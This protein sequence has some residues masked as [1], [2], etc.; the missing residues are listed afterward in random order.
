MIDPAQRRRVARSGQA[1]VARLDRVFSAEGSTHNC[2][3]VQRIVPYP[4]IHLRLNRTLAA[5]AAVFHPLFPKVSRSL[6]NPADGPVS[7][8]CSKWSY[9]ELA[10][11]FHVNS[12]ARRGSKTLRLFAVPGPHVHALAGSHKAG[13]LDGPRVCQH[14]AKEDVLQILTVQRELGR[15]GS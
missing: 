1:C 11:R 8:V 13:M 6:A 2:F 3:F 9:M 14:Y 5:M 12:A 7:C 15:R 10:H 4:L